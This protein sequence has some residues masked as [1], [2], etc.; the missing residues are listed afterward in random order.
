MDAAFRA[1]ERISSAYNESR[2]ERSS[3]VAGRFGPGS[4]VLRRQHRTRARMPT[5]EKSSSS[6]QRV[7][8]TS[9]AQKVAAIVRCRYS[10]RAIEMPRPL[11]V[12]GTDNARSATNGTVFAQ[13][14]CSLSNKRHIVMPSA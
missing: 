9:V 1:R 4:G 5:G 3:G 7:R 6:S 2:S 12:V 10:R 11:G 8:K 13:A 14:R